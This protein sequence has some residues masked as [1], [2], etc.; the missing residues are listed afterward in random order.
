MFAV[1][2]KH[3]WMWQPDI[4]VQP[5]S[6]PQI[7]PLAYG[8]NSLRSSGETLGFWNVA[9][10]ICSSSAW[11]ALVRMSDGAEERA[12]AFCCRSGLHEGCLMGA[13]DRPVKF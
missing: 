3:I 9:A 11:R 13:D 1:L 5:R 12:P 8:F 7:P 10:G 6:H 4:T 2:I